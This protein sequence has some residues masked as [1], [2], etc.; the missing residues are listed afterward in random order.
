M[1]PLVLKIFI[2]GFVIGL[3]IAIKDKDIGIVFFWFGSILIYV[4]LLLK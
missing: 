4:G 1:T 2:A 3:I